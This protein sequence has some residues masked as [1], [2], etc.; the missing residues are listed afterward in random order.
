MD[1][2]SLT[3]LH[4][5]SGSQT[6]LRAEI[7]VDLVVPRISFRFVDRSFAVAEPTPGNSLPQSVEEFV[8][9]FKFKLKT[10]IFLLPFDNIDVFSIIKA[11]LSRLRC[12]TRN[13]N[14][15]D[16]NN[17]NFQKFLLHFHLV[18]VAWKGKYGHVSG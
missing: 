14:G 4:F 2:F 1:W 7:C 16:N 10:H 13:I 12:V 9:I 8:Y 17:N 5:A 11:P 15:L 3:L 6:N 18:Q